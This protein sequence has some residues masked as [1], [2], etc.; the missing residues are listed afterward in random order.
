MTGTATA[1]LP[2]PTASSQVVVPPGTNNGWVTLD[3]GVVP[4]GN[5][6]NPYARFRLSTDAGCTRLG[7][8]RMVKWKT[9]LRTAQAAP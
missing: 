4:A 8:Q 7:W 9:I 1:V 2:T 3:F 5:V 6:A